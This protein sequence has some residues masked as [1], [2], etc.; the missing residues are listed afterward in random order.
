[1]QLR[2]RKAHRVKTGAAAGAYPDTM[3]SPTLPTNLGSIPV[4]HPLTGAPTL[5]QQ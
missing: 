5:G 2:R 3:F 1:M 4:D